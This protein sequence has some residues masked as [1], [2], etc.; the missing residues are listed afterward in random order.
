MEI[1]HNL[2]NN[3]DKWEEG[4]EKR[5]AGKENGDLEVDASVLKT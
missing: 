3:A 1:G 5:N 4:R 2:L